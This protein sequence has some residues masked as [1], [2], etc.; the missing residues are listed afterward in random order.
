MSLIL[1]CFHLKNFDQT[2]EAWK[3]LGLD[4]GLVSW[5]A[6]TM[7]MINFAYIWDK[8]ECGKDMWPISITLGVTSETTINLQVTKYSLQADN[9]LWKIPSTSSL[10]MTLALSTQAI[11]AWCW[12]TLQCGCLQLEYYFGP[13][14]SKNVFI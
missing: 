12:N 10:Y 6:L 11:M 7:W 14:K 4:A 13:S 5:S 8:K 3:D 1:R 2:E 9:F